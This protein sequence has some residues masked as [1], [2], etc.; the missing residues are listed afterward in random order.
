MIDNILDD[1]GKKIQN[2]ID[3][4]PWRRKKKDPQPKPIEEFPENTIWLNHDIS[5][6]PA[7]ATIRE[8]IINEREIRF[9]Y[10][11]A[12]KWPAHPA[13]KSK[14]GGDINGNVWLI[15]QPDGINW[16]AVTWEWLR[17]GQ[18][19]KPQAAFNNDHVKRREF[20]E[21]FPPKSGEKIGFMVSG[22]ARDHNRTIE[23]RSNIIWTTWP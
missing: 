22:F 14:D 16:Y 20:N 4:L 11:H 17:V 9:P 5:N 6:W 10:T 12:N 3:R 1:L 15:A 13:V 7:T 19:S 21:W 18:Q 8:V 23:E 2:L